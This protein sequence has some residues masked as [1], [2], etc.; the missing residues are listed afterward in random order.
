MNF[1]HPFVIS[2]MLPH[3]FNHLFGNGKSQTR[4]HRFSGLVSADKG[5]EDL[6]LQPIRDSDAI[7]CNVNFDSSPFANFSSTAVPRGLYWIA[8]DR[9]LETAR[10]NQVAL[11]GTMISLSGIS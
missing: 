7:V 3:V 10:Y 6:F 9:I 2:L 4:P 11:N 8:F 5:I 1:V